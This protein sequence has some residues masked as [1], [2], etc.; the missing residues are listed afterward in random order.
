MVTHAFFFALYA[1]A[2]T[3]L[4]HRTTRSTSAS[5]TNMAALPTST[6]TPRAPTTRAGKAASPLYARTPSAGKSNG[7]HAPL[8]TSG[9]RATPNDALSTARDAAVFDWSLPLSA[10]DATGG[11]LGVLDEALPAAAASGGG[12]GTTSGGAATTTAAQQRKR[13]RRVTIVEPD[14]PS[15]PKPSSTSLVATGNKNAST[16]LKAAAVAP[17][18]PTRL[19]TALYAKPTAGAKPPGAAS[20]RATPFVPP[21]APSTPLLQRQTAAPPGALG[22][23]ATPTMSPQAAHAQST[24]LLRSLSQLCPPVPA[25]ATTPTT[26]SS[27]APTGPAPATPIIAPRA[28]AAAAG[29]A[30]NLSQLNTP[31]AGRAFPGWSVAPHP[32]LTCEWCGTDLVARDAPFHVFPAAHYDTKQPHLAYIA[33]PHPSTVTALGAGA[34]NSPAVVALPGGLGCVKGVTAAL[35]GA[36]AVPL[37]LLPRLERHTDATF[38]F[39]SHSDGVVY[40][41]LWCLNC[42]P[43]ASL[44]GVVVHAASAAPGAPPVGTTYILPSK[45]NYLQETIRAAGV[46]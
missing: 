35:T 5:A 30:G 28:H 8:L 42:L 19:A 37:H 34:V 41:L 4:R 24:A 22:L 43:Q 14:Q 26:L 16:E 33:R 39:Y 11:H 25:A 15:P 32:A 27:R 45:K 31:T 40:Q 17:R 23:T 29:G 21:A 7:P 1:G 38:T 36:T 13:G 46:A 20:P 18:T 9:V 3:Q 12:G 44:A 10:Y 6:G 2:R